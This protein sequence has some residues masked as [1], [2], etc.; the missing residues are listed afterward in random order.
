MKFIRPGVMI[1]S[2]AEDLALWRADIARNAKLNGYNPV[3]GG[4]A[5]E[6]NFIFLRPKSVSREMP[7]VKP[8]LDKLIRAILDGLTGVAYEDDCQVVTIKAS[9]H[10]GTTNGAWIG[11]A[12][13]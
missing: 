12:K 6:I 2:R 11:V 10:Y 5:V 9:K 8:D 3:A 4:V 1:H 7:W 13:L